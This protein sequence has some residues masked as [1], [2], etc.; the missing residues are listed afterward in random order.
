M[1][2][3]WLGMI[4]L[5]EGQMV[6]VLDFPSVPGEAARP[7]SSLVQVGDDLWFTAHPES[8]VQVGIFGDVP[9]AQKRN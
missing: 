5:A 9:T 8:F 3:L 2:V 4:G 7:Y 6:K 1:F